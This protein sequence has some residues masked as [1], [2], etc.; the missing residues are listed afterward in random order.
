LRYGNEVRDVKVP[1]VRA[2]AEAAMPVSYAVDNDLKIFVH[3]YFGKVTGRDLVDLVSGLANGVTG[4]GTYRGFAIFEENVDLSDLDADSLNAVRNESKACFLRL[5][6][7]RGPSAAVVDGAAEAKLIMPLWNALCDADPEFDHRFTLF[8]EVAPA[9]EFLGVPLDR[10]AG[11]IAI[12]R[13]DA[14]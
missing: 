14:N 5:G 9:L 10:A 1:I 2:A 11:L 8:V 4:D 6:L 3:Y 7:A 12:A 13:D